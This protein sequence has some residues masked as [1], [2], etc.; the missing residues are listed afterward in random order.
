MEKQ[1]NIFDL[2]EEVNRNKG[3][4]AI[5]KESEMNDIFSMLD[6]VKKDNNISVEKVRSAVNSYSST[7]SERKTENVQNNT[8]LVRK[9]TIPSSV[10]G[11]D[12]YSECVVEYLNS[13]D[14]GS[15][16]SYE[17]VKGHSK[18]LSKYKEEI[19]N[20]HK[21]IYVVE[22]HV[23]DELN[24]SLNKSS[25]EDKGYYDGLFYVLKSIKRAKEDASKKV[26]NKLKEKLF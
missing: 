13:V 7:S 18:A 26:E 16:N 25:I 15:D 1:T 17:Y 24:S 23:N 11:W 20:N 2:V 22:G 21:D 5:S 9:P 14:Y 19:L 8:N 4:S 10:S 3:R 12:K 6:E